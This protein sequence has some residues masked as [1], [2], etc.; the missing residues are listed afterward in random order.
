[1]SVIVILLFAN[2]TKTK[3]EV[4]ADAAAKETSVKLKTDAVGDGSLSDTNIRYFGRWDLTSPTQYTGYW[5]G[6]YI[7]VKFSGTTIKAKLGTVVT[8][9]YAQIDNGA[10]VAFTGVS[11]TVNLTPAPLASGTHSLTLVEAKDS[12]YVF[13]FQGFILDAGAV[14]SVPAVGTDLIEWV[15]DSI[16]A[17]WTDPRAALDDYAWVASDM[18]HTEHTQIA[19]PGVCLVSGFTGNPGQDVGY[20]KLKSVNNPTPPDWDFTKYTARM[21]VINLGTN[22]ANQ[23]VPDATFQTGYTNFL[24]NIRVKYPNAFIFVMQCLRQA[25]KS[26][27]TI[28][29]VNARHAA[30]DDKVIFINTT[31]WLALN[32][33]DYTDNLHPSPAGHVKVANFLFPIL[34]SYQSTATPFYLDQCDATTGWGSGNTLTLNTTDKKQGTGALQSVGAGTDEFKR[35][36]PVFN[37]GASAATGS[38]QFW[39][40]V[41]DVTKFNATNQIEIG[42]GGVSDVNEYSWKMGPVVNGW[43]LITKAFSSATVTGG[44]PNLNA[45]NWFRI[46][47]SKNGSVTTKVDAIQILK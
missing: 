36:I 19:Y 44:T 33:S 47:H 3:L 14:T 11:G 41:S 4:P 7:K 45:I 31:N 24:A 40:Y 43:N 34:S 42:S 1:M 46:Y 21:V 9:Y 28:A 23:G 17:G 37:S 22:D 15:G 39:Y 5:A 30:G 26:V 29:A 8:N 13:N 2:C 10:W 6:A 16:T 32:S 20:F 27:P 12:F 18:M 25:I 35:V 38:L